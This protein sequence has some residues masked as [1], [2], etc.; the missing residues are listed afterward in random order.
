MKQTRVGSREVH[1]SVLHDWR[2]NYPRTFIVEGPPLFAGLRVQSVNLGVAASKVHQSVRH[3]C[4]RL[5]ADLVVN[6]RVFARLEAPFLL[7]GGGVEPVKI[8]VP[9]SGVNR[10]IRDRGRS[11]YDVPGLE[12]PFQTTRSSIQGVDRAISAAEIHDAFLDRR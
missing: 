6:S 12:L 10:A 4:A 3:H 8:A 7:T 9:A 1:F 2:T 11:M 5:N